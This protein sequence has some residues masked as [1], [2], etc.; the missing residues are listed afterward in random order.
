MLKAITA[1]NFAIIDRIQV[2]FDDGLS[3][4]TG[5]TGAGKSILI[6]AL[7]MAL[8][9][10][11][12]SG[13][14]QPGA[15]KLRISL[16][17]D[18]NNIE[19][20]R[21]WV[22]K[23]DLG[24]DENTCVLRRTH[25]RDGRSQAYIN[26]SL[27]T[28]NQLKDLGSII[29]DVVGQNTHQQLLHHKHQ[30][31]LL[32][33]RCGH[34]EQVRRLGRIYRRWKEVATKVEEYANNARERE[35]RRR[36]LLEEIEEL[37]NNDVRQGEYQEV[38]Q[39]HRKLAH[40]EKFKNDLMEAHQ[41]LDGENQSVVLSLGKISV[42]LEQ[43]S[44]YDDRIE[45]IRQLVTDAL[46]QTGAA[47][48]EIRSCLEASAGD[49]QNFEQLEERLRRLGDLAKRYRVPPQLLPDT[50]ARLRSE[51]DRISGTEA[52]VGKL[53][54]EKERLEKEY[55]KA[56]GLI[57]RKRHAVARRIEEDVVKTLAELNMEKT[58]FEIQFSASAD[59]VPAP[60]GHEHVRF[61]IQTNPG[62]ALQPLSAVASGGE[63]SRVSL[64]MQV[65]LSKH[66]TTP[67]LVFDEVDSGVGGATAVAVGKLL[68]TV[69]RNAQV[70]C[71]THLPQVASHA[72]RHYRVT[73]EPHQGKTR[74][75]VEALD[76]KKRH[77]EIA[78]MM[79]GTDLTR[80]SLDHAREMLNKAASQ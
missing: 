26:G 54:Q 80:Q 49:E 44:E 78:R 48:N 57:S 31:W 1:E 6:D 4:L 11:A 76:D 18:I 33:V 2:E 35:I 40:G 43:L 45:S 36:M 50:L 73:K 79:A 67:V 24:A 7:Q 55:K 37:Q 56:A 17:F 41:I 66:R 27:V 39:K 20:A 51:L 71:I 32:D 28:L 38:E 72:D 60:G 21:D 22:C 29:V 58:R 5:E 3:V 75:H 34:I 8:G 70:F 15:D 62:H 52:D 30:L 65:A 13:L 14:I 68:K 63:L 46:A 53:M 42:M 12:R 64:A 59:A 19:Q 77:L 74:V 25:G 10:R 61:M 69:S 16:A 47:A 9:R 23:Y